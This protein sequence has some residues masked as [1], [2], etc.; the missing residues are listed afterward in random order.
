M[1]VAVERPIT[2]KHMFGWAKEQELKSTLEEHLGEELTKTAWRY[3]SIDFHSA[4]RV[5]ELK[6]RLPLDKYKK[7]QLPT[8]FKTWL[9]PEKK[10]AAARASG[11]PGRAYYF[12]DA[13]K[14]LWYLDYEGAD[15]ESFVCGVPT[16]HTEDHYFV[17]A[18][19]WRRVAYS[20]PS[21][22]STED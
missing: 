19:L 11:K 12:W 16:W 10:V 6:S 20:Y 18:E 17:P 2:H 4:T 7:P 1:A 8:S 22:P 5:V 13:D 15:W 9:L 21:Q 3:D 14:S